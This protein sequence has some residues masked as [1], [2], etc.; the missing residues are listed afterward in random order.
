MTSGKDLVRLF[1]R[2]KKREKTQGTVSKIKPLAIA[3]PEPVAKVAKA[4]DATVE[5]APVPRLPNN[6]VSGGD[7]VNGATSPQMMPPPK[8]PVASSKCNSMVSKKLCEI[9][10]FPEFAMNSHLSVGF[11][12]RDEKVSA[13]D[14]M[15]VSG[16]YS[17][18]S[19]AHGAIL[20]MVENKDAMLNDLDSLE[21]DDN[22]IMLR[23][24]SVIL[25]AFPDAIKF[26]HRIG[27][28]TIDKDDILPQIEVEVVVASDAV[29]GV[30]M[31]QDAVPVVS[32]VMSQIRVPVAHDAVQG[33]IIPKIAVSV[34][35][36]LAQAVVMPEAVMSVPFDATRPIAVK[37]RLRKVPASVLKT[38]SGFENLDDSC[39]EGKEVRQVEPGQIDEKGED[40]GGKWVISDG[41]S[42]CT[43]DEAK[44]CLRWVK[45][46]KNVNKDMAKSLTYIDS[47]HSFVS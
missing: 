20:K 31:A 22:L 36:E 46:P 9:T 37:I 47:G 27:V 11:R 4:V 35:S 29:Q 17:L 6:A 39:L 24:K 33:G 43:G 41:V 12:E 26:L 5:I 38:I 16:K 2:L 10:Q 25:M 23:G 7:I 30:I 3:E 1:K 32:D 45:N 15:V 13:P 34:A 14:L 21:I 18:V 40:I 28:C 19:E 42:A 8:F 44:I